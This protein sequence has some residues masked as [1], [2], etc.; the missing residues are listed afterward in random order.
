MSYNIKS[1]VN[2]TSQV[3]VQNKN[4]GTQITTPDSVVHS[5]NT[6]GNVT[7]PVPYRDDVDNIIRNIPL[8]Q[9]GELYSSPDLV[10]S[11]NLFVLTFGRAVPLFMSGLLYSLPAQSINL[12]TIKANPASTTFYVYAEL[13][14]GVAKYTISTVER[15]ETFVNMYVGKVITNTTSINTINITKVSRF[16]IYRSSTTQQGSAFPVSTGKATQTG[17]ITW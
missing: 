7:I 3:V 2:F 17:T 16:D 9:Y 12:S 1:D 4:T 11:S 6:S 5:T 15:P 13:V 14:L 10:I 8:S